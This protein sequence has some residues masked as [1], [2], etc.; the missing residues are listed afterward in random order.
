MSY[1]NPSPGVASAEVV[2]TLST[3]VAGNLTLP[4]L[5]TITLNNSNDVHTWTQLD[6]TSKLQ[7]PTLATN[8]LAMNVVLDKDAFFGNASATANSATALGLFN[9]SKQKTL[10]GFSLYMGDDQAGSNTKTISG[11]AYVTGLAPTVSAD[12]PVWVSPV[13]LTVSGD[14]TV[15]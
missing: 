2:L 3:A 10:I 9:L 14:Y 1:I 13:T 7:V 15:A 6:Q 5:T 8:S 11:N 12:S 4:G